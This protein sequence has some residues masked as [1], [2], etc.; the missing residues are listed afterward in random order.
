MTLKGDHEYDIV[1]TETDTGRTY[2]LFYSNSREW[3]KPGHLVMTIKA[4][5]KDSSIDLPKIGRNIDASVVN[6]L[7]LLLKFS[8]MYGQEQFMDDI[9]YN[10]VP[11]DGYKI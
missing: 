4:K 3:A 9:Q 7:S 8:M 5:D 2:D 1:V 10:V 11:A 6:E